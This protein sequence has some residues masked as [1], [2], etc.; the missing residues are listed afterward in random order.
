MKKGA[1]ACSFDA[2]GSAASTSATSKTDR[3]PRSW[4]GTRRPCLRSCAGTG[5]GSVRASGRGVRPLPIFDPRPRVAPGSEVAAGTPRWTPGGSE[6]AL[7]YEDPGACRDEPGTRSD[8][9]SSSTPL[10][11]GRTA[12]LAACAAFCFFRQRGVYAD[13][14]IS[15]RTQRGRAPTRFSCMGCCGRCAP[16]GTPRIGQ[17]SWARCC[18]RSIPC[19]RK[20]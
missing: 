9:I 13:R 14:R 19:K 2:D 3:T 10:L 5:A 15:D 1:P 17:L 18:S 16:D 6:A 20:R 11:S 8:S 12:R 7:R 4:R